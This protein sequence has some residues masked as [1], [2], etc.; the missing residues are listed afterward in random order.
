MEERHRYW[1]AIVFLCLL[2][3]VFFVLYFTSFTSS[4]SSSSSAKAEGSAFSSGP[5][6]SVI[7]EIDVP[8]KSVV[9]VNFT[10]V[11]VEKNNQENSGSL[12]QNILINMENNI[13]HQSDLL[14]SGELQVPAPTYVVDNRKLSIF[15]SG[16][17][18]LD[19]S[20]YSNSD[21]TILSQ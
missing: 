16:I 3:V 6:P 13:F 4:S 21:F 2:C 12:V 17:P 19:L 14:Y 7:T 20:F 8:E 1:V 11:Y 15:V 10:L 9:H 18:G 5:E